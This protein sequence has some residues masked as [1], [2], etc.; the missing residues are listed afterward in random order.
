MKWVHMQA[1]QIWSGE[2]FYFGFRRAAA[3]Q[4]AVSKTT[5]AV[6]TSTLLLVPKQFKG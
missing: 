5:T 2:L 3:V 6:G 4:T 1:L